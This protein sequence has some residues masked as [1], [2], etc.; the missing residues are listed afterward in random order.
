MFA[1]ISRSGLTA[2]ALLGQKLSLTLL[3]LHTHVDRAHISRIDVEH[4]G[5]RLASDRRHLIKVPRLRE[6]TP[7]RGNR[8]RPPVAR[9]HDFDAMSQGGRFRF[10]GSTILPASARMPRGAAAVVEA[11]RYRWNVPSR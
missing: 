9:P 11:C 1:G 3:R 7:E 8:Y 5:D 10:H 2:T 4:Q 6:D